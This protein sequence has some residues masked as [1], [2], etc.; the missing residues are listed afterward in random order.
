MLLHLKEIYITYGRESAWTIFDRI[1]FYCRDELIQ[2]CVKQPNLTNWGKKVLGRHFTGLFFTGDTNYFNDDV[3]HARIQKWTF[4]LRCVCDSLYTFDKHCMLVSDG[5]R[6]P[7]GHMCWCLSILLQFEM[8]NMS[9]VPATPSRRRS[10]PNC[11]LLPTLVCEQVFDAI[12][13]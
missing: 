8:G 1:V 4:G 12:F 2:P 6:R 11:P 7:C 13:P 3:A 5:K 10:V 9:L